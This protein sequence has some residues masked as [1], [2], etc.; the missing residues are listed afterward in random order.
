M[1]PR[2]T[3]ID[4]ST[5]E[6]VAA[7]Y[8]WANLTGARYRDFSAV[9]REQR[10]RLRLRAA[11][12]SLQQ[13]LEV[14]G[15]TIGE[16]AHVVGER[17]A[18]ARRSEAAAFAALRAIEEEREIAEARESARR[19]QLAFQEAEQRRR[20]RIGPQPGVAEKIAVVG[21]ESTAK[22]ASRAEVAQ[23]IAST[24]DVK[25]AVPRPAM[26]LEAP[27]SEVS[28]VAAIR[29]A[30]LEPATE[31]QGPDDPATG[32]AAGAP[33]L[34]QASKGMA[35]PVRT[36]SVGATLLDSR[37]QVAS[38]WPVLQALVAEAAAQ[39]SAATV[40]MSWP[41]GPVVAIVSPAGGAGKTSLA[42]ALAG[43]LAAAGERVLL[44]DTA[45]DGLLPLY[46]GMGGLVA[47]RA[48][49]AA[50][51]AGERGAIS[52]V[53]LNIAGASVEK[54]KQE[55]TIESLLASA[56]GSDRVVIDLAPDAMWM[57]ERLAM[58]RP[59]VLAAMAP[60]MNSVAGLRGMEQAFASIA[61]REGRPLLPFYVL[62]RFDIG[63][64]LH[65]DIRE[66]LRSELGERLI[67][68]AVRRSAAVSE[69]LAQGMTAV[70]YA[71]DA[72]VAR[73]YTDV[74]AWLRSVSPASAEALA[75]GTR[76]ERRGER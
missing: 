25:S 65:L 6:D 9:R 69:A 74:A 3:E 75:E 36:T 17:V 46:F 13:E 29:P 20:E 51:R 59:M 10:A 60:D 2:S 1:S 56:Q 15:E 42:A 45:A 70:D 48:Q 11:K 4:D 26:N 24:G 27:V 33:P 41:R 67:A 32:A 28:S 43:A 64:P 16:G 7:L 40:R 35:Q 12:Q 22:A 73:D 54:R 71:P 19:K 5:P 61:D 8:A 52:V 57:V 47:G 44:A 66:V 58:L 30:W 14:Q 76:G 72:P 53:A 68:V 55:R 37:A 21:G 49:T 38:R 62:N 34:V 39:A 50:A 63:L 23:T 31:L 18:E